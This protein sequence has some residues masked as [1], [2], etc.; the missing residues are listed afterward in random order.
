[1]I[2][3]FL[4]VAVGGAHRLLRA[5]WFVRR[6]RTFGAHAVA[7]TPEGRI[8]LV[9]L[10]YARGWRLPG[11]GRKESEDPREA[12]LRELREEIGMIRHGSVQLACELEERPDFKRDTAALLIVRD[13]EYRPR[14]SL[15]IESVTEAELDRLP[16]KMSPR[17]VRWLNAVRPYLENSAPR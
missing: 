17:A 16:P 14:W 5:F 11:G 2:D 1:M 3:K 6:P 15:E 8:V 9:K 12:V 10:R 4:R 13:V 7:L